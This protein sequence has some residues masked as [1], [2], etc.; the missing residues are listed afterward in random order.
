MVRELRTSG[1]SLG[2]TE[3][4]LQPLSSGI[5]RTS[6]KNKN[7]IHC[8]RMRQSGSPIRR[9]FVTAIETCSH[10]SRSLT[11]IWWTNRET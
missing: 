6:T 4:Y 8:F 11:K 2:R 5:D 10:G 7:E 9:N 1:C 3:S